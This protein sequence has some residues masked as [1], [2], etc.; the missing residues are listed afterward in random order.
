MGADP[1]GDY[2]VT[3][4]GN[5][6]KREEDSKA[7]M[8]PFDQLYIEKGWLTIT[9]GPLWLE[10]YYYKGPKSNLYVYR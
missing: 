8:L 10:S 3:S 1:S 2:N 9:G 6:V 4:C 5:K 7:H